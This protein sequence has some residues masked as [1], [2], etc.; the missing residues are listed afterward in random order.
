MADELDR[1]VVLDTPWCCLTCYA[2]F[3]FG[4]LRLGK[5]GL[6]CPVSRSENTGAADGRIYEERESSI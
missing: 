2:K 4:K 5:T 1:D 6:G 3:R